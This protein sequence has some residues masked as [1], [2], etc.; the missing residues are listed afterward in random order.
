MFLIFTTLDGNTT[1]IYFMF[2][3]TIPFQYRN[4]QYFIDLVKFKNIL[5][6]EKQKK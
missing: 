4:I 1:Q 5:L 6:L 2:N 3:L